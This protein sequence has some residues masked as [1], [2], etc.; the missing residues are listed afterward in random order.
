MAVL[1]LLIIAVVVV[2]LLLFLAAGLLVASGIGLFR[3]QSWAQYLTV[4]ISILMT[5]FFPIGTVLGIYGF[6][7]IPA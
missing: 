5:P 4:A 7:V 1:N 2:D 3:R 6:R